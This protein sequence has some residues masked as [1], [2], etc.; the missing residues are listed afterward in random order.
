M[1][2]LLTRLDFYDIGRRFV[3]GRAQRISAKEIDT[4]G[5]D[6]NLLVGAASFMASAVARQNVDRLGALLLDVCEDEDLDRLV[7][8]R[9]QELRK[10]ASPAVVPLQITRPSAL[11][12]AG[13]VPIGTVVLTRSGIEYITTTTATFTVSSLFAAC[14]ARAS[15][16]GKEY[17]VGANQIIRF[18]RPEL[19]FDASLQVN[20]TEA[21][22]G[23]EPAET[24]DVFRD[25]ARGFFNAA[26][27]GT[28]TAIENG[29]RSV[30]GVESAEAFEILDETGIAIKFVQ[31]FIADSS[32]MAN[33]SLALKVQQAL[34]EYRAGGIYV[35][36]YTSRPVLANI[37]FRF[38]F[39]AGVNTAL[40]SDQ[41][42]SA[43]VAYINSLGVNQP[44][45]RAD[46]GAVLSRFKGDGLLVDNGT[47]VEPVG[48]LIPEAGTT[49]RIR[50]E[51]VTVI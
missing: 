29:A 39:R 47:I 26:R 8:D 36:I 48:D 35:A 37:V 15:Q 3:L 30:A 4:E 44:L 13:S 6:I 1:P 31:L 17:Q 46:L 24:N 9:Y 28:L 43:T 23:G 22:A 32:G 16:A 34:E 21:S 19:L 10:G 50:P 33:S 2:E 42:R 11:V 5:S 14:D 38:R 12:G 27:R 18:A 41:A 7:F 25:R 40:I 20:N 45:F 49:I 51:G